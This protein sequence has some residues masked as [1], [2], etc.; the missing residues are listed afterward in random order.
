MPKSCPDLCDRMDYSLPGSSVPG[1][2]QARIS[3]WVAIP[4]SRGSSQPRDPTCVSYVSCIADG[5]FTTEE[6]PAPTPGAPRP[7]HEEELRPPSACPWKELC[8]RLFESI[9]PSPACSSFGG[10]RTWGPAGTRGEERG[11]GAWQG[12]PGHLALWDCK[13]LVCTRWADWKELCWL[14]FDRGAGGP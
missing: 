10:S 13:K 9:C 4:F 12:P 7:R 11:A 14:C 6:D 3:K 2:F 8:R 5:F 1:I